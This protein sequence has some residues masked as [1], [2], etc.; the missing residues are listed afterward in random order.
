[1]KA[2]KGDVKTVGDIRLWIRREETHGVPSSTFAIANV[3]ELYE[4]T[5]TAL[6]AVEKHCQE[7]LGLLLQLGIRTFRHGLLGTDSLKQ[8]VVTGLF[9]ILSTRHITS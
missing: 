4:E 6:L 8:M 9:Q 7:C 2:A 1:M 3:L 5:C